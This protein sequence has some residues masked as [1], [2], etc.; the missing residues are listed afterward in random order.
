MLR[1]TTTQESHATFEIAGSL[2]PK[3]ESLQFLVK[4]FNSEARQLITNIVFPGKSSFLQ[5][6]KVLLWCA[7]CVRIT[8]SVGSRLGHNSLDHCLG[9]MI[10]IKGILSLGTSRL[11]SAQLYHVYTHELMR[12]DGRKEG[13]T[14]DTTAF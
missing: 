11:S 13:K 9:F 7:F 14:N 10:H 2:K 8:C 5:P 3:S 12:E 1:L 6:F 4:D